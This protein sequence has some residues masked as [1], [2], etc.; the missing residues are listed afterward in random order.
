MH[1]FAHKAVSS[2]LECHWYISDAA[3]LV[4]Q[5]RAEFVVDSLPYLNYLY[6]LTTTI[7]KITYHSCSVKSDTT[8]STHY[9]FTKKLNNTTQIIYGRIFNT[10]VFFNTVKIA[11]YKYFLTDR[12]LS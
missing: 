3:A 10:D 11:K 1:L 5:E 12:S 4:G 7:G 8:L 2:C 6:Y 9:S